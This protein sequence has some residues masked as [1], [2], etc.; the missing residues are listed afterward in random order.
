[1]PEHA[2]H[3]KQVAGLP[4]NLAQKGRGHLGTRAGLPTVR[5][6]HR[7]ATLAPRNVALLSK[8]LPAILPSLTI[9]D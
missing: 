5:L 7:R 6:S 1:M 3:W 8:T 4:H 2:A 9:L